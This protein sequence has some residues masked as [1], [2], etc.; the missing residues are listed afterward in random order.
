MVGHWR[1]RLKAGRCKKR[2][3]RAMSAG[4]HLFVCVH[5]RGGGGK[6]ACGE[7]GGVEILAGVEQALARSPG[8]GARVTATGCLGPCFDGPN[9][10][11]YPDG[12][13]YAGLATDDTAA[14]AAHASGGAALA[15]KA[16]GTPGA[17]PDDDLGVGR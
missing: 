12:V 8:H 9:A 13:W 2:Y 6:P 10:V 11:V 5:R 17:D 14:L 7:R 15:A 1:P 4:R 16:V 3:R